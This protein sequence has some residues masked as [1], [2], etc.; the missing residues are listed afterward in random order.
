MDDGGGAFISWEALSL[1]KDLGLRPKRTLRLVLW[2]GEEQG[3]VGAHQYYELHKGNIS[4]IDLVMESDMGTFMPVG[5]QF[6]GSTEAQAIMREVM[7]LLA[8]INIT[9]IYGPAD[10]TDISFWMQHG[11]PVQ[12]DLDSFNLHRF[13]K[14]H[15]WMQPVDIFVESD[16]R[17]QQLVGRFLES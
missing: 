5:L 10:G 12:M 8:P 9:N 7:L 16:L 15:H 6:T 13:I 14:K 11:V 17:I 2:T 1:I 3:G 4:N